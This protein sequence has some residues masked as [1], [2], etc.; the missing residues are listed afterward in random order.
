MSQI[1][2]HDLKTTDT[3]TREGVLGAFK[4]VRKVSEEICR[5]LETEDYVVQPIEDIS[6]PKWHL[7]HMTWFYEQVILAQFEPDFKPYSD[8]FFY[9]FN[10]YYETFG[11]RLVRSFRGT[12]SRPTVKQVYEYRKAIN[13]RMAV[14]I[15]SA[16][17][18]QF[19]QITEFVIL[20]LNHEQQHQELLITDIKGILLNNPL[21][22]VYLSSTETPSESS[23]GPAGFIPFQGGLHEFGAEGPEF[24]YDN[25]TPRHKAYL[26]DFKLMDRLITCGEFMNFIIDGGYGTPQLWLSAGWDAVQNL[27][28]KSPWYW[29]K[30]DGQ[31][32]IG[33]M[34]GWRQI[35]PNEPVCHVSHY[36]AAAYARWAGKR[37]PTEYEWELAARSVPM[38]ESA[39]FMNFSRLHPRP[40]GPANGTL[41]QM[42]GDVWEWTNSA[43]LPYPGY[44]QAMGA[45]GEYNGKFMNN[46]I[47]ARGGSCA[48]PSDHYRTTYRNFFQSDRRWQ[49]TGFRLAEDL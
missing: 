4:R 38:D 45:L 27:E 3:R 14:L 23:P 40:A 26:N 48:T 6:P 39:N 28:W 11:E 36:E 41:R 31:W 43:Y 37:L 49:Y 34:S 44:V 1:Q 30:R 25:E 35:D 5:P 2:S 46:Q 18:E 16:P 21:R 12:L 47:V 13:E 20:G 17:E 42:H 10:S 8:D 29:E 15:E 33:T 19:D 24:C 22:P 9:V 7:G 32:Q